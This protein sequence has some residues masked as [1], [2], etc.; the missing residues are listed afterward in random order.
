LWWPGPA[1]P[2]ALSPLV[3]K[4]A[5]R[6]ASRSP[7]TS[8]EKPQYFVNPVL[9]TKF[10]LLNT[11]RPLFSDVRARLAVNYAID[12][13]AL[14]ALGG[15]DQ[16][17][18]L[19]LTDHYLPPGIAGFRDAHLYPPTPDLAKARR[20][21]HA[22]GRTAVLYTCN[23]SPC[24]QQAQI[25]QT[26]LAAIGLQ[27]QIKSFP[28]QILYRR[29]ATPGAPFDLLMDSYIADYPDPQGILNPVLADRSLA[30]PL[31]NTTS[32]RRLAAAARLSGPERYLTY[33]QLDLDLARN[34]APLIAYGNQTSSDFFAARIGCQTYSYVW[35]MDLGALCIKHTRR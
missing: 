16:A 15:Y 17:G 2:R 1:T 4:L 24:P 6:Y 28:L 18:P 20:L 10:I 32:L 11:H 8:G 23:I 7:G 13:R 35:G 14:A 22:H 5:A 31:N 21:M 9:A 29:V 30:P 27:V 26:D 33:G 19:R 34:A 3:A 25:V 12:R